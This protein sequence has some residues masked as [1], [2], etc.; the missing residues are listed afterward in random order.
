MKK[1]K[2]EGVLILKEWRVICVIFIGLST[3]CSKIV[4]PVSSWGWRRRGV[5]GDEVGEGHPMWRVS[6]SECSG[7]RV[8]TWLDKGR[9]C[10][11][12]CWQSEGAD[13]RVRVKMSLEYC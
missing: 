4:L 3:Q 10:L 6:V 9:L 7:R 8:Q 13:P 1:A 2:E 11:L 12:G 5:S